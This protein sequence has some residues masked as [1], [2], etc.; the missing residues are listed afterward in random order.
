MWSTHHTALTDLS[1]DALWSTLCDVHSGLATLPGGDRFEPDG[2]LAVGTRI[3]VTP[4]GQ[5]AMVSTVTE[6]EAARR[7]ADVTEYGG[8]TLTFRHRFDE[9]ADELVRVTHELVIDGPGSDAVGPE[10]GPQISADFPQQLEAL[11]DAA[12][13]RHA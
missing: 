1:R 8:L 7:Y 4:E 3:T 6:F 12:R 10:L 11:F 9:A 13:A 2:P 5:D